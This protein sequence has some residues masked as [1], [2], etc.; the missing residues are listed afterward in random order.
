MNVSAMRTSA[1]LN[2][3]QDRRLLLR[4]MGRFRGN[5]LLVIRYRFPVRFPR[6]TRTGVERFQD[7]RAFLRGKTSPNDERAVLVPVVLE[8]SPVVLLL[9]LFALL[10]S[11]DLTILA[12]HGLD[13]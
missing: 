6:T 10:G 12:N 1:T 5:V 7:D 9:G 2:Q 4:D 11:F 3:S 8:R 13:L